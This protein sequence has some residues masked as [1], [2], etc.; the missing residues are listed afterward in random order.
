MQV[1]YIAGLDSLLSEP[2]GKPKNTGVGGSQYLLQGTSRSR[3]QIGVSCIADRRVT[4]E[5]HIVSILQQN[6]LKKKSFP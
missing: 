6:K 3:N 1:S 2:P 4:Q 5:A